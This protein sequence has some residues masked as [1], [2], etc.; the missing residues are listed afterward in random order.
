[1][2]VALDKGTG[3]AIAPNEKDGGGQCMFWRASI[4]YSLDVGPIVFLMFYASPTVEK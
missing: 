1:M 2:S 3:R 4:I